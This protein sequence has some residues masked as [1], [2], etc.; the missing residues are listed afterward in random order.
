MY[1]CLGMGQLICDTLGVG[2][3]RVIPQNLLGSSF[4]GAIYAPD[5]ISGHFFTFPAF[6][7]YSRAKM[8]VNVN[9]G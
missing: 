9:F 2:G 5:Y 3:K 4:F 6:L 1:S 8:W 7:A